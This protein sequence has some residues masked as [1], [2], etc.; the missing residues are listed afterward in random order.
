MRQVCMSSA[1][2][3][4]AILMDLTR[5]LSDSA[6]S[7]A[8][9]GKITQNKPGA[10]ALSL[11]A[12][13]SLPSHGHIPILIQYCPAPSPVLPVSVALIA[14]FPELLFPLCV[15]CGAQEAKAVCICGSDKCSKLKII[16]F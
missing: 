8:S 13:L 9:P 16:G 1:L 2:L 14:G 15:F 6:L 11:C 3:A 7:T 4:G 5:C 10:S 12:E